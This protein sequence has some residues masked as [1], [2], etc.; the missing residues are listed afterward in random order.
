MGAMLLLNL[1]GAVA[2]LLYATRMVRTGVERASGPVLR[3][4]LGHLLSSPLRATGIGIFLAG[5]FQ[6]ATAVSLLLGALTGSAVIAGGPAVAAALGAD[7]GSALVVRLLT[8]DLS[9][10]MPLALA[11]G[12]AI[13][14]AT[15]R[16]SWRQVGRILVGFGLLL[17]SLQLIGATSAPLRD[18]T[19]L[20]QVLRFLSGDPVTAF[21][22]AAIL[23]WLFHSS[24]AFLLLVVALAAQGMIGADLGVVLVLGANLGGGL[25]AAML[26][27]GMQ[28]EAR[29]V[30][31]AN[32]AL[33]GSGAVI[34]L[35]MVVL[36]HLPIEALGATPASRIMNSHI[37]FNLIVASFG[38]PL[39]NPAYFQIARHLL[40]S[41]ATPM[42][43]EG[44]SALDETV[45]DTPGLALANATR[46]VVSLCET[47]E[48]LLGSVMESYET[49][50]DAH[51]AALRALDDRIDLRH[52]QIKLYLARLATRDLA[53]S[54]AQQVEELLSSCI[55]LE[56][57]ADVV[58]HNLL[59]HAARKHDR[60]LSFSPDGWM[61]LS[62]LHALLLS[63]ARMAFNVI[64]SRDRDT[65]LRLV[66]GK[67]EFRAA[68][69]R[70]TALH[71]GRL[72]D[73][74]PRSAESSSLHLDTIRDLKQIN[75]L[76]AA[77][78]YPVLEEQG[79]L[80]TSRLR[81]AS[82]NPA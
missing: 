40:R 72:R 31:L 58:T 43:L 77:L 74:S 66:R 52:R 2:L 73:G 39:A 60:G 28:P 16:R 29:A 48:T 78:A 17:L 76:L 36:L 32:L 70:A 3:Q 59:A 27:R 34:A 5:A 75:S 12:T 54:D 26:S 46:E 67:E 22:V 47:V 79:L 53:P 8:L 51:I 20:P 19:L 24:V 15:E 49:P 82:A 11:C 62:S 21:L 38:M 68:E 30:P 44:G 4:R 37:L 9:W 41:T 55:A 80:L 6:S 61:E 14:M 18:S 65:A 71:F 63:N 42:P 25:I 45:L 35:A 1:S 50:D 13:F 23:T 69:R 81:D 7:L 33:R 57:A 10:I 56:Q 64:V